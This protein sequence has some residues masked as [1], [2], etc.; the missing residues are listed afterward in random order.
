MSVSP[1]AANALSMNVFP[2]T[3]EDPSA[4]SKVMLLLK[5]GLEL[6]CTLPQG[7]VRGLFGQ[8]GRFLAVG[9]MH[10]YDV[11]I[12]GTVTDRGTMNF[13]SQIAT[14]TTNGDG[15]D[16]LF[17]VSGGTGYVLDLTTNV[18]TSVVDDVTIGAMLDGFFLALDVETSTLKISD[19]LDGLTWDPLQIAQ[20]STASDPWKSLLV[21]GKNIW[22]FGE[23]TSE[24]WYNSGDDFPFA[25]FPGAL[26]QQGI[27]ATFAAAQVG[28]HV[29]WL[30]QNAQG[31][32]TV[33]KAQG[34]SL[35]KISTYALDAELSALA[36]V[37]DAEVYSYQ[38][39][40]HTFWVLNIPSADLTAVWDDTEKQW[41]HRGE[42]HE[43]QYTV[44]RPR[45]HTAIFDRHLVGDRVSGAIYTQSTALY[46]NADGDGIRWLRRTPGLMQEQTPQQNHALRL[47]VETGLGLPSGQGSDPQVMLRYSDNG[48]K[49][50]SHELWRS[51]GAQGDYGR[52]VEWNRLG[53]NRSPRVYEV[54]GSDPIPWRLLGAFLNPARV[55][56]AA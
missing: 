14:M 40:G 11:S 51:V 13:D 43:N 17:I 7:P 37:A 3:N 47:F 19:L 20:R 38:E 27:A 30:A 52:I 34:V 8:S 9:G 46:T 50:W 45:V 26:M 48:G 18:L 24:L 31:M 2:A 4:I 15:G 41:H 23:F 5:P 53:L 6:F 33:V 32:R 28:T 25:P 10:L 21:V 16:Q 44:D 42:W 1:T 55:G 35:T 49:T 39:N 22:L 29:I 12:G 56:R 54:V 36:S